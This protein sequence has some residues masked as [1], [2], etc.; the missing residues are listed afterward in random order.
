MITKTRKKDNFQIN[1]QLHEQV[2]RTRDHAKIFIFKDEKS[3]GYGYPMTMH[4]R[5]AFIRNL[6]EEL[7]RGQAIWA[8]H[9]HDFSIFEIGEYD[10]V[11]GTVL[12]YET[13]NCLGL[14][15]DFRQSL[16]ETKN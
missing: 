2:Q 1:E 10:D 12:M 7:T 5:G 8:R 6:Q 9:P 11:T 13:K 3:Q 16:G 4:T 15:Q 14:V